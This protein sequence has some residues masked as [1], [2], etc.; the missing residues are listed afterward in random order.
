MSTN[1]DLSTLEAEIV[2]EIEG[3]K[4]LAALEAVRV[5]A[6]GKKGRVSE[7]DEQARRPARR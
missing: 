2:A 3:A 6:L 4:D 1:S 7:L 5:A